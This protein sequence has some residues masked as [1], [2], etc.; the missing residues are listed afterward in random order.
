MAF[1]LTTESINSL[2]EYY[3]RS[4][5]VGL[6]AKTHERS[7][8]DRLRVKACEDFTRAI[9]EFVYRTHVSALKG[10]EEDGAGELFVN[11]TEKVKEIILNMMKSSNGTSAIS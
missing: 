4:L 9:K 5:R 6:V 11:D 8:N 2:V 3:E 7:G 10:L 1:K